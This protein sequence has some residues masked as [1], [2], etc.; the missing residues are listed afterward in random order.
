MLSRLP[1]FWKIVLP[2]LTIFTFTVLLSYLT[3]NALHDSME[4]E[5]LNAV[6]NITQ[7]AKSIVAENY[8]L[9]QS[10]ELTREEAQARAIEAVS[11]MRYDGSNYIFMFDNN[12]VTVSHVNKDLIG[13]DLSGLK[14][15]NGVQVIVELVKVA[16]AGGG[17]LPYMW[18]RAGSEVPVQKLSWAEGFEPWGWM[19]GTGV[20]V[21]DLEGAYWSQALLILAIGGVGTL[22]SFAIAFFAIR[23]IVTAVAGL[24]SNMQKLADGNT[25]VM[26]EGAGRGDEL[27][28]MASAMEIF[29]ENEKTRKALEAFT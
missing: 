1:V 11:A 5:R 26:I 3:L 29:V 4:T 22:I 15:P 12:A 10:G 27:G 17:A 13:K 18:P 7:T 24:T 16:K 19:I 20:Y 28:Q 21:D 2:A 8:K 6:T 9:E 23:N 25:D 14:D